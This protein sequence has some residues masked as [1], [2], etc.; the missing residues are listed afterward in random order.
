[1]FGRLLRAVLSPPGCIFAPVAS[2]FDGSCPIRLRRSPIWAALLV[3]RFSWPRRSP[4]T[5][6]EP[7]VPV[8]GPKPRRF[9]V[10][11]A[12]GFTPRRVLTSPAGRLLPRNW[13]SK[14]GSDSRPLGPL[15][16][17]RDGHN[18]HTGVIHTSPIQ[19]SFVLTFAHAHEPSSLASF[20]KL[21]TMLEPGK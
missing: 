8:L 2:R 20:F 5:A 17:R 16:S 15:K 11:P 10:I 4:L 14:D 9:L 7:I 18:F 13:R 12:E 6:P 1:M 3:L 21:F 19:N